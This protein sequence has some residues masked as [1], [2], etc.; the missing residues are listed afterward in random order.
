MEN[1]AILAGESVHLYR[2]INVIFDVD[3]PSCDLAI[4]ADIQLWSQL[5]QI[6]LQQLCLHNNN[7]YLIFSLFDCFG[8]RLELL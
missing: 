3:F 4:V 8:L 2:Y 1:K 5:Q 6:T 7:Q